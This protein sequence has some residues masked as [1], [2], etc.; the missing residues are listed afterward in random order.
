MPMCTDPMTAGSTSRAQRLNR[1]A[2]KKVSTTTTPNAD[3][4]RNQSGA[5]ARC[6][7]QPI[8]NDIGCRLSMYRIARRLS[9]LHQC[10]PPDASFDKPH[11]VYGMAT[12]AQQSMS[13]HRYVASDWNGAAPRS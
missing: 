6:I 7:P 3:A 12:A 4:D 5:S 2:T 8:L 13:D 11:I 9:A 1:M 10:K